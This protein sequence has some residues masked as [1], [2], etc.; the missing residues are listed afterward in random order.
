MYIPNKPAKCGQKI[1]MMC[2]S[3]TRYMIDARPY[4][5]KGTNIERVPLGEYVVKEL[6]RSIYGSNRNV[7]TDDWFTSIPLAKHLLQQHCKLTVVGTLRTNKREIPEETKNSRGRAIGT[8]M[9]CYDGPLTLLSF[10]PKP[11][12]MVYL[13]SSCDEEGTV[14]LTSET[15]HNYTTKGGV[16]TFDQMCSNIS[17]NRKT[18]LWPMCMFYDMLYISSINSYF[19]YC[20]NVLV[21][22]GKPLSPRSFMKQLHEPLVE[23]WLKRQLEIPTMPRRIKDR[24]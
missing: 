9:F 15:P 1:E 2:D 11:S 24:I 22:G 17:C 20:H 21:S 19:L 13:V 23:P 18:N 3:G 10:K 6:A 14:N 4:L 8:S 7:T 16:D 12:K 5:G